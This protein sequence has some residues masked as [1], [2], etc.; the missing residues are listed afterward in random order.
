VILLCCSPSHSPTFLSR[1]SSARVLDESSISSFLGPLCSDKGQGEA[2][3]SFCANPSFPS[4]GREESKVCLF[5]L[6]DPMMD[7]HTLFRYF[8]FSPCSL[9]LGIRP[10]KVH[11][12]HSVPHFSDEAS[13]FL[14]SRPSRLED[15]RRGHPTFPPLGGGR[16][17]AP[18]FSASRPDGDSFVLWCLPGC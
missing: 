7:D 1:L 10:E 13:P 4:I 9:L 8:I 3:R 15:V 17:G 2:A 6:K 16:E 12:R 18:F 14:S 5:S 11:G